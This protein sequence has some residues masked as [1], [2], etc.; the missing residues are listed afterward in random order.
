[1]EEFIIG[2]LVVVP[3]PFSDL[4]QTKNRPALVVAAYGGPDVILAQITSQPYSDAYAIPLEE[5]EI[6]SGSLRQRSYIRPNKLFTCEKTFIRKKIGQ[7]ST[8]KISKVSEALIQ[9]FSGAS[10]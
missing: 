1:V 7:L 2:D 3:F 6:V 5:S 9:L 8:K 10:K 4:S